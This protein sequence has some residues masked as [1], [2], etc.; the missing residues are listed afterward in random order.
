MNKIEL[1]QKMGKVVCTDCGD[2]ACGEILE[3]CIFIRQAIKLFDDYLI[4]MEEIKKEK[5]HE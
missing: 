5:K 1:M 2:F 3:D 4:Q